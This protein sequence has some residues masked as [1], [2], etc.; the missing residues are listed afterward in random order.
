MQAIK[1]LK[2]LRATVK[3]PGSKSYTQRAMVIAA[4]ARGE[5]ELRNV[6]VAEDTMYLKEALLAL[7][8]EIKESGDALIVRGTAGRI[9]CPAKA[10]FLGNNGT[11]LRFLTTLVALGEGRFVLTGEPR[12]CERPVQ[13]LLE[14]LAALG[15]KSHTEA[16]CPPITIEA[17]GLGGGTATFADIASSQYISSL[18]I[19][20]PYAKGE[21]RI[22]ISGRTVSQ[23]Y[24][25]MTIEAMHQFGI[26]VIQEGGADYGVAGGQCYQGRVYLVEGDA[27]TASYFFLAAALTGGKVKVRNINPRSLQGDIGLLQIMETLGCQVTRGDDHVELTGGKLLPGDYTFDMG[28]LPDMVPTLAVL[29][30]FREGRTQITNVAH[31]R[32][33]ESNRIAA[34]VREINRIGVQAE[35]RADGLAIKGGKPR[36]MEIE[37]YNDHR[38]AMSFAIAGLAAPGMR[39][40]NPQCVKKSFP[41]FWQ[42]LDKLY[43]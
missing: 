28:D 29:A 8:T 12:L 41:A 15:V 24:I 37:T 17:T 3:L 11:A 39:I 18:L 2:N 33:K 23:P 25:R 42:E 4:L 16:G 14:A 9:E 27:S 13:P 35:E 20:A 31:L 43:V 10:L 21:V 26:E 1:P 7:G 36:G 32:I 5:S 19:C 30:A 38:I 22:R 34:L 40:K 6:L